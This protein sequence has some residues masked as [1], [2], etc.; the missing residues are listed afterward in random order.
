MIKV[1][2]RSGL[3]FRASLPNSTIA[4]RRLSMISINPTA[5]L[6]SSWQQVT[7]TGLTSSSLLNDANGSSYRW[8]RL[9]RNT[10]RRENRGSATSN[11]QNLLTKLTYFTE[12]QNLQPYSSTSKN[13]RVTT[14]DLKNTYRV[15]NPSHYLE[16]SL[17]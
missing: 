13:C 2:T 5:P 15:P 11:L 14:M 1:S 17:S 9:V 12:H 3:T 4:R 8:R 16:L 6:N 7:T 10:Q